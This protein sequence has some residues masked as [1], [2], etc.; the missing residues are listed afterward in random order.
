MADDMHAVCELN[1]A[2]LRC[3]HETALRETNRR[4]ASLLEDL[5]AENPR[6]LGDKMERILT[7]LLKAGPWVQQAAAVVE[8]REEVEKYRRHLQQLRE[9]LPG[10]HSRLLVERARLESERAHLEA[11]SA[12]AQATRPEP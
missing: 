7:E 2:D 5:S 11:A 4:L 8:L 6:C 9:L 1:L 10:V 3:P 12:W